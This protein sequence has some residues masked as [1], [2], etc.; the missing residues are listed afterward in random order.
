MATHLA[1]PALPVALSTLLKGNFPGLAIPCSRLITLCGTRK[2]KG[3]LYL[4]KDKRRSWL[5]RQADSWNH[6]LKCQIP[7]PLIPREKPRAKKGGT[8]GSPAFSFLFNISQS[9]KVSYHGNGNGNG[10]RGDRDRLAWKK[11]LK[12]GAGTNLE[13]P[14]Q[15]TSCLGK[16]LPVHSSV[17]V[18]YSR[19]SSCSSLRL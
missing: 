13:R 16:P 8:W 11:R 5:S 6:C 4:L 18:S 2:L 14:L 1:I 10:W 9:Q 15:D 12:G 17:S 3:K 7:A 19:S